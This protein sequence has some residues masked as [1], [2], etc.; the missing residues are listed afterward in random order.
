[1][2]KKL[3]QDKES[4]QMSLFDFGLPVAEDPQL[5]LPQLPEMAF[6]DLLDL[7]KEML[8]F[9][10][11]GHPLDAYGGRLNRKGQ[12]EIAALTQL[13]REAQAAPEAKEDRETKAAKAAPG[14]KKT[15][16]TPVALCG[17]IT[18]LSQRFTKK[19]ELMANFWLEDTSGTLR[20][21]VFPRAY[22]NLR[23]YLA[24]GRVLFVD[25]KPK[26]EEGARQLLVSGVKQ[27]VLY[28][29]LQSEDEQNLLR[30]I[31]GFLSVYP[32]ATPVW[33]YYT[34]IQDYAPFPGV[35]GVSVDKAALKALD[36]LLGRENVAFGT[37]K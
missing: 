32:G 37:P 2:A 35:S 18:N 15:A 19:G 8:G 17:L 10:V 21:T 4:P 31:S 20:C 36:E 24:N 1:L 23:Q 33:A 25:G 28:L 26:V 14:V 34:D 9:Y 6:M 27:P 5:T 3:M 13:E 7:E 12:T 22:N 16:E 30:E 11:S 29:R